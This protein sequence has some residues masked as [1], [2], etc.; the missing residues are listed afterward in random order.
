[1][2]YNSKFKNKEAEKI[3]GEFVR[4][5]QFQESWIPE[6]KKGSGGFRKFELYDL[7]NDPNQ[8][9]DIIDQKP[10]LFNELKNE[11]IA[12]NRSVLSDAPYWGVKEI[13][14]PKISDNVDPD[15]LGM[16]LK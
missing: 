2:L 1:M 15:E 14:Q 6:I 10:E 9:K 5:N 12:L 4:L 13:K 3:R 7:K 11:L 16:L 8:T